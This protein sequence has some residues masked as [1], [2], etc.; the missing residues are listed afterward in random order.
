MNFKIRKANLEDLQELSQ[1]FNEY[2]VFYRQVSNLERSMEFIKN[3]LLN[4]E[5]DV[6][7]AL[8]EDKVVGFVQLYKLFHYIKLEKQWLL[9]DQ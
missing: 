1:L 5:S 4:N 8:V 2:R 6:F 9:S 3:R 7:I